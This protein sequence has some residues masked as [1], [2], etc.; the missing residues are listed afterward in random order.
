MPLLNGY[1]CQVKHKYSCLH[2]WPISTYSQLHENII[3]RRDFNNLHQQSLS[4][5]PESYIKSIIFHQHSFILG[6]SRMLMNMESEQGALDKWKLPWNSLPTK[7]MVFNKT[8]I[9]KCVDNNQPREVVCLRSL[10]MMGLTVLGWDW[11]EHRWH[12]ANHPSPASD[13][14]FF[15]IHCSFL[16]WDISTCPYF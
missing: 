12:L 14:N 7:G 13:E 6:I 2:D 4:H 16:F 3:T 15:N 10:L 9:C 8:G 5:V 11:D 1:N